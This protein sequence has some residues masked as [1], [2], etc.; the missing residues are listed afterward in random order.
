MASFSSEIMGQ[1]AL[2][3]K[4]GTER[5]NNLSIICIEV[6]V[7]AKIFGFFAR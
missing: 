2:L 1:K 3:S 7:K 6:N 5:G 4:T